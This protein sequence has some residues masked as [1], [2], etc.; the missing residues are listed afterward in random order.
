MKPISQPLFDSPAEVRLSLDSESSG[1]RMQ[2][3]AHFTPNAPALATAPTAITKT[4]DVV[5]KEPPIKRTA[6]EAEK[7]STKV[8]SIVVEVAQGMT[9]T[10]TR[11]HTR[12][13]AHTMRLEDLFTQTK[14]TIC[15]TESTTVSWTMTAPDH[16]TCIGCVYS[17]I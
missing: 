17:F 8:A 13:R 2:P 3:E 14:S 5:E 16:N 10:H 7:T 9:H 6:S 11:T 12:V 15:L 4:A 1:K